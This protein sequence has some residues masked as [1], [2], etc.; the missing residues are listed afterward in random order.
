MPQR[1][2]I[3]GITGTLG[4]E[5]VNYHYEKGDVIFGCARNEEKAVNWLQ[6][7]G[8]KATLFISDSAD[9][10]LPNTDCSR[11][12][13][14]MDRVYH[15]AA[16]KHVDICENQPWM[17]VRENVE[18]TD[19]IAF[20]CQ[21]VGVDFVFV[22]SDK[23]CLP[24]G[25]YGATKLL[26]EKVTLSMGGAV[27]RFG[28]L[29]GSSGSVFRL[30]KNSIDRGEKIKLTDPEMTRYF[31][32]V[33]SAAKFLAEEAGFGCVSVPKH[34]MTVKMGEVAR[35]L[36]GTNVEIVGLRPGETQHQWL[37]APGDRMIETE[38]KYSLCETGKVTLGLSSA[39]APRLNIQEL[40]YRLRE[41]DIL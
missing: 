36:A 19:K 24:Q 16:M 26:A 25:V 34:M 13:P 10:S 23:A 2:F 31:Y 41:E 1:V 32:P 38:T 7:Y 28:N 21:D 20:A 22:S 39:T 35:S 12:L 5:L 27:V 14:S 17:S 15:C 30:W 29:I 37:V 4:T 9:L 11:L 40:L 8:R 6:D 33:S 3:T 18:K